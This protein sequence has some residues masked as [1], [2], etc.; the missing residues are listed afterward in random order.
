VPIRVNVD[1]VITPAEEARISVLDRGLI[2]G[3]SVYETLRTYRG[4]PFLFSRHFARLKHSADG[5]RLV[6]RWSKDDI[7][8][9]V[10]RTLDSHVHAGESRIRV[11]VTRGVGGISL[12]AETTTDPSL[13]IIVAPLQELPAQRYEEGANVVISPVRRSRDFA[14]I[15]S[16][17]L[18]Q[19]VLA[20]SDAKS[21]QAFEAILLT[22]DGSLSDAITSNIY[23]VENDRLLTPS[24]AAG[25]VE[26]I[27]RSVVLELARGMGLE[28]VEGLFP[29]SKIEC[30]DEMFLTSTTREVVPIVNVD[31][32]P[33]GNGRPGPVTLALLKSYRA[34]IPRLLEEG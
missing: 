4:R 3:D 25:I 10:Q 11:M 22:G 30:T 2:Y 21:R 8:S 5:V 12:D 32:K 1:G 18:I 14:D 23:L 24:R 28:V 16:G 6:L 13:I 34:S 31:G 33:V 27:T 15:K 17:S 26:G 7:R 29:V 20:F 19:Q 9:E